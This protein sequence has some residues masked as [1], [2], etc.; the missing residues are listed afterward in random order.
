MF[1]AK[2][3]ETAK[4]MQRKLQSLKPLIFK[5]LVNFFAVIAVSLQCIE[6][7]GFLTAK[8]VPTGGAGR[9]AWV[10]VFAVH[11][12]TAKNFSKCL[13]FNALLFCS[14]LCSGFAVAENSLIFNALSTSRKC[15]SFNDLS[16]LNGAG[17]VGQG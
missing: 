7:I 14:F 8:I 6:K 15:L 4:P 5:D 13:I 9:R 1:L 11:C 12:K 3:Q 10:W 2:V 16:M 17:R